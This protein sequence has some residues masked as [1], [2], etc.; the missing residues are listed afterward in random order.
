MLI[1]ENY[2][3]YIRLVSVNFPTDDIGRIIQNSKPNENERFTR[4]L[5]LIT[6][7]LLGETNSIIRLEGK[8]MEKT[9]PVA[10]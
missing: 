8:G 2:L 6:I 10:R 9:D 5:L 1:T 7:Y 3:Q 4:Y